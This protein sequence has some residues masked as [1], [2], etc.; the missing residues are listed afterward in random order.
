VTSHNELTAISCPSPSLCAAVDTAGNVLA[1]TD[2]TRGVDSWKATRVDA[3]GLSG[4]SCPSE[5]FCAVVSDD[6]D[7][8]TSSDPTGDADA[9]TIASIGQPLRAGRVSCASRFLCAAV[10]FGGLAVSG[11]PAGASAWD[12]EDMDDVN[13]ISCPSQSLCVA[14]TGFGNY[15]RI[16]TST[17]P[18][19]LTSWRDAGRLPLPPSYSSLS[20]VS[21][22]SASLCVATVGH[23]VGAPQGRPRNILTS[24]HPTAGAAAWKPAKGV[25]RPRLDAVS[26]HSGSLC[27]AIKRSGEA[28]SSTHPTGGAHAWKRETI[29]SARFPL[30]A[31]SCASARVCLAVDDYGRAIVGRARR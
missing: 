9:W 16:L 10:G 28:L 30:T 24:T 2:P 17:D 29:K 11:D 12:F 22:A 25:S 21:C 14:V 4:I 8:V 15:G 31:I 23:G 3:L 20:D 19:D 7:V 26:C 6:D 27:V 18:A 5:T 1:S 13:G